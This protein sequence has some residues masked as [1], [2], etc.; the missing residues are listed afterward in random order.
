MFIFVFRPIVFA[1]GSDPSF[2]G[3]FVLATLADKNSDTQSSQRTS[4]ASNIQAAPSS[5]IKRTM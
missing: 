1:M 5:T 3:N 2:E 4:Q